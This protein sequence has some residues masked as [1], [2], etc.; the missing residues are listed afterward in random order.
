MLHR[1]SFIHSP[2][3][4]TLYIEN[5]QTLTWLNFIFTLFEN[6]II[7]KQMGVITCTAEKRAS[8]RFDPVCFSSCSFFF[9]Q[10]FIYWSPLKSSRELAPVGGEMH[11]VCTQVSHLQR[12]ST[13][14]TVR[15]LNLS[16]WELEKHCKTVFTKEIIYFTHKFREKSYFVRIV[17]KL[18]RISIKNRLVKL[19]YVW[20]KKYITTWQDKHVEVKGNLKLK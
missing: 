17:K 20:L 10:W 3:T 14:Q 4:C 2:I 7:S 8:A 13:K 15:N 1:H 11:S 9:C 16:V 18:H 5:K 12:S 19:N 6:Q